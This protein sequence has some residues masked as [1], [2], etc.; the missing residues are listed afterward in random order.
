MSLFSIYSCEKVININLNESNQHIVIEAVL[1]DSTGFNFVKLSKT[2]SFYDDS[3]FEKIKNAEVKITDNELNSYILN[4]TK[5]GYYTNSSFKGKP[6]NIYNLSI[7]SEGQEFTST[8]TMPENVPIDSVSFYMFPSQFTG[9]MMIIANMFYTDSIYEGNYYRI[10]TFINHKKGDEGNFNIYS[11]SYV[12]GSMSAF[13]YYSADLQ[14]ADS[15][16]FHLYSTDKA[17]YEYWRLLY[18]NAGMGMSST[19][20]N[21]TSN[22][23]GENVVGYFGAYSLSTDTLII[24][25]LF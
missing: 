25:P 7:K 14:I 23:T 11:D 2:G 3:G 13:S 16:I 17:N 6:Q 4:E 9:E 24:M 10:K 12:N 15:I 21:P 22:I 20:G 18:M 8:S 5:D 1:T 19:P